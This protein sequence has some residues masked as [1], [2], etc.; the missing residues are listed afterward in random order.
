MIDRHWE[1]KILCH[2]QKMLHLPIFHTETS[3]KQILTSSPKVHRKSIDPR[4]CPSINICPIGSII[5]AI[6]RRIKEKSVR[7]FLLWDRKTREG[8]KGGGRSTMNNRCWQRASSTPNF[9]IEKSGLSPEPPSIR[10]GE[11]RRLHITIISHSS[12]GAVIMLAA[13]SFTL[14]HLNNF[15]IFSLLFSLS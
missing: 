5:D 15:L 4:T 14:S 12:T 1:P 11:R 7:V 2:P 6:T 13:L 9:S 10:P 3:S 8:D